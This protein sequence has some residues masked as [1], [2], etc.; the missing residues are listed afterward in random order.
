MFR[1]SISDKNTYYV[2]EKGTYM[3]KGLINQTPVLLT[4]E[5]YEASIKN[6]EVEIPEYMITD[7]DYELLKELY[8]MRILKQKKQV[9][10]DL[11]LATKEYEEMK[12]VKEKTLKM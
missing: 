12:N 1:I 5:D 3:R 11:E 7:E 2:F 9:M 4:E 10:E 8:K 6:K